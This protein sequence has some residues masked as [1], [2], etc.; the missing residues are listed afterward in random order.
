MAKQTPRLHKQGVVIGDDVINSNNHWVLHK[1]DQDPGTP[2]RYRHSTGTGMAVLCHM[3]ILFQLISMLDNKLW[4]TLV[5]L[6]V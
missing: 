1:P 6:E 3:A 2:H 5:G 4:L